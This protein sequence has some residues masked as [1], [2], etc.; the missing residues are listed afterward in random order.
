VKAETIPELP[1]F[2]PMRDLKRALG[3]IAYTTI[4]DMI[5]DGQLP[6]PIRPRRGVAL[7]PERQLIEALRRMGATA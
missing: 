6:E 4:N 5:A 1:R 7:F 3:N 2:V